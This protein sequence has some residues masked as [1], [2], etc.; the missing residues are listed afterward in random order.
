M[1]QKAKIIYERLYKEY[2]EWNNLDEFMEEFGLDRQS[3]YYRINQKPDID[4]A[5]IERVFPDINRDW[6]YSS[7]ISELKSL[8]VKQAFPT[9]RQSQTSKEKEINHSL[10]RLEEML[11]DEGIDSNAQVE[12]IEYL[13]ERTVSLSQELFEISVLLKRLRR[14]LTKR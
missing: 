6:L 2:G 8:P 4:Y 3:Y 5:E 13:Q 10:N 1:Q 12:L 14:S 7:E 11:A 9:S